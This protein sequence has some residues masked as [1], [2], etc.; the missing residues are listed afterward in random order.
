MTYKP[1]TI[2][3][4]LTK[5][6]IRGNLT[7]IN[8]ENPHFIN[9]ITKFIFAIFK[10]IINYRNGERITIF[11]IVYTKETIN[12]GKQNLYFT[13]KEQKSKKRYEWFFNKTIYCQK[14]YITHCR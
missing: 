8:F 4:D 2:L 11:K 13:Y 3:L 10:K 9:N 6:I 14:Q 12:Q 7:N 5:V 1:R